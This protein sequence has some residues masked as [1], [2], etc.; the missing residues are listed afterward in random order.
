MTKESALTRLKQLDARLANL[1]HSLAILNWDQETYLPSGAV[2]ERAEQLSILRGVI[3]DSAVEPELGRLL[4]RLGSTTDNPSG[5]E[6]LA[7]IDRDFLRVFRRDFDRERLLPPDFVADAA[8]AEGLSQ[9]AW[10]KARNNDDFSFFLPHLERMVDFARRRALYW[11]FERPYDGLLDQHEEGL[12]EVSAEAVLTPLAE[13]LKTLIKAIMAKPKPDTS[14]LTRPYDIDKQK[15]FSR[16]TLELIGFDFNR[17]R[18]DISAHPFTTTLGSDDVRITTR[19]FANNPLSGLFSTIHEAGHALYEL[20]IEP[21]LRGSCL[22]SGSSMGIHESQS[23]L[24]EN[25]IGRSRAFWRGRFSAFAALFPENLDGVTLDQFYRAINNVEPSLIRV[26]AD[27]L[28]YSLHIALRFNLERRLFSG[29]LAV[30]DLPSAWRKGMR[31]YLGVEPENDRDGVLQDIHWS[32]GAFGYFPSYALGNLYGLQFWR[33]F[34]KARPDY[35]TLLLDGEFKPILD[36]FG[37]RI[38][39]Y[40]RRLSP[41]ALINQVTGKSLDIEPFIDYLESKYAELY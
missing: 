16:S 31:D 29:D 39:R 7:A 17:G 6:G 27:E 4:E 28:S 36:W 32:F 19:F 20:G 18:I 10:S 34:T 35:E 23:R 41:G 40:G 13:K 1:S 21:V 24:W 8:K 9:A 30:S 33:E 25:V 26:D 12:T 11:G 2:E 38:H 22:A 37:A 5:D 14:F 15:A 3:H